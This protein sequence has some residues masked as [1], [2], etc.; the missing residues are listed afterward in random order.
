MEFSLSQQCMIQNVFFLYWVGHCDS[1]LTLILH[2]T[3][4]RLISIIVA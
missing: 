1:Q 2:G 4:N 3:L